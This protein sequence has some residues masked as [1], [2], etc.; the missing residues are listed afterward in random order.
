LLGA[1]VERDLTENSDRRSLMPVFLWF[2][3][4]Q[5]MRVRRIGCAAAGVLMPELFPE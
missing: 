5:E 1:G 4:F 2:G 3:D